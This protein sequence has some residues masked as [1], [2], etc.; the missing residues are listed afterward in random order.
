[1]EA[2]GIVLKSVI[3]FVL[4]AVPGY[5]LAKTGRATAD[6][7]A[8]LSKVLVSIGMPFLIV[9]SVAKI[10]FDM[11][12]LWILGSSA[13]I[14][15]LYHFILLWAS[16]FV[17]GNDEKDA[18]ITRFS[19]IFSNNGFLG[20]PLAM[21]IFGSD[22]LV[23]TS[24]IV[25]NIITNILMQT[26]GISVIAGEKRRFTVKILLNPLLIA[27]AVGTV[28][29]LSGIFRAVPETVTYC[30]YLSNL[31]TPLSMLIIGI[32]LGGAQLKKLFMTAR[33]YHVSLMK[34]VAV[35]AIIVAVLLILRMFASIPN[36]LI[37]GMFI[38][39]AMPT[40]GLAPVYAGMLGKDTERAVYNTIGTTVLSV[41]TIPLL[42]LL[43]TCVL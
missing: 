9:T 42:Y 20:L 41:I 37:I 33:V 7:G 2:F 29:N 32:Q 23:L 15:I 16:R 5:L 31:V 18:G 13:L 36:D 22:S 12:S 11:S 26:E 14:G 19:M 35:P 28:V 38:A 43:L 40:A 10:R 34:L 1:M 25:V 4:L 27:F 39:F 21:A 30:T 3:V 8:V 24:V 6:T 17:A